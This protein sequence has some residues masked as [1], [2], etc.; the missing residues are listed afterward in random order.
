MSAVSN[1][2]ST[3]FSPC[4]VNTICSAFPSIGHCLVEA[5]DTQPIYQLIQCG[6]GIKEPGE[7]CDTA[8]QDTSCCDAKTCK[9][10]QNAV[11]E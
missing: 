6:N 4:S 8:G 10:K 3:A 9:F 5:D 11:C 7:D 1:A 2:S